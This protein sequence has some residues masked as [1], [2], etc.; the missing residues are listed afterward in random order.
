[1]NITL[2]DI[3]SKAPEGATHYDIECDYFRLYKDIWSV[4]DSFN[5]I[6]KPIRT[7]TEEIITMFKIKPL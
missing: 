6:W 1:M 3:R 4:W 2:D 5:E 7:P